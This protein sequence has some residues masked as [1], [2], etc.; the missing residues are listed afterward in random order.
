MKFKLYAN[1]CTWEGNEYLQYSCCHLQNSLNNLILCQRALGEAIRTVTLV[2]TNIY[3]KDT[4]LTLPKYF[5][6]LGSKTDKAQ[7]RTG[8][9]LGTQG[10]G[11]RFAKSSSLLLLQEGEK[12]KARFFWKQLFQPIPSLS[13]PSGSHKHSVSLSCPAHH[14]KR[15]R[16]ISSIATAKGRKWNLN[17]KLGPCSCQ[18]FNHSILERTGKSLFW[19]WWIFS[20]PLYLYV[21][22][23]KLIK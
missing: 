6:F 15:H 2:F 4:A 20:L 18:R 5:I 3:A 19:G 11:F 21:L 10:F 17:T 8:T 22:I 23:R 1:I 16:Q 7:K 12:E 9:I 13:S 14:L